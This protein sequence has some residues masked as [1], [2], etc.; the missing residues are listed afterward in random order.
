[1][2]HVK[3]GFINGGCIFNSRP[4]KSHHEGTREKDGDNTDG[5]KSRIHLCRDFWFKVSTSAN[6]DAMEKHILIPKPCS[7]NLMPPAKKHMPSTSTVW[8]G[9]INGETGDGTAEGLRK[10]LK[11]DPTTGRGC[12]SGNGQ[13]TERAFYSRDDCTM[14]SSHLVKAMI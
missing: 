10:L 2:T 5:Q 11:I 13:P 8:Q 4:L 3:N 9:K 6:D 12:E 1:M 7:E 14:S